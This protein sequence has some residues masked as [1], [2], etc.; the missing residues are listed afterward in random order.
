MLIVGRR[1]FCWKISW[2]KASE[3]QYWQLILLTNNTQTFCTVGSTSGLRS[4]FLSISLSQI[5]LLT[6]QAL[7]NI[8]KE[9]LYYNK[10]CSKSSEHKESGK[11]PCLIKTVCSIETWRSF[12][13]RVRLESIFRAARDFMKSKERKHVLEMGQ[14][15]YIGNT[16][17]KSTSL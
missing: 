17:P 7:K 12:Q 10:S 6:K 16:S 8:K 13:L 15:P 1:L 9:C 11:C 14:K 5:Y 4:Y 3:S 2:T